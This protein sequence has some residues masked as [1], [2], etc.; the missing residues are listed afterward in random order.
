MQLNFLY[1]FAPICSAKGSAMNMV[2]IFESIPTI[3]STVR[4]AV[5]CDQ[6]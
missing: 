6:P 5:N 4:E 3:A 1:D 2:E